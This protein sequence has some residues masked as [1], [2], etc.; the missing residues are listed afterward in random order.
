[1]IKAPATGSVVSLTAEPRDRVF[2]RITQFLRA[3]IV[4]GRLRPGDRLKPERELAAELQVGRGSL[5]EALRALEMLDVV[6]MRHGSGVYVRMPQPDVLS[7]TFGTLLAMQPSDP[8]QVIE[9]RIALECHAATLACEAARPDDLRRIETALGR[10]TRPETLT[11]EMGTDADHAFHTSIVEAAQN[12]TL[13]F[14]YEAI[15]VL[16]RKG[17]QQRWKRLIGIN[18]FAEVFTDVHEAIFV[19]ISQRDHA[20]ATNAIK[21]HFRRIQAL[22][23]EGAASSHSRPYAR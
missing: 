3:E 22:L 16:L 6:E 15:D 5:R 21:A 10:L 1:M 23:G 11:S 7:K 19:A 2:D 14:L 4:S 17:H 20:A 9:A 13:L 18:G 12:P 8:Q